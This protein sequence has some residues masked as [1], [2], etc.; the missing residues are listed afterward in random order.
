M[1]IGESE[2]AGG[3][4]HIKPFLKPD[5]MRKYSDIEHFAAS[6]RKTIIGI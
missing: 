1:V 4:D 2:R 3:R 5:F 6:F